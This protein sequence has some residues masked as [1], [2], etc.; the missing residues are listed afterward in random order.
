MKEFLGMIGHGINSFVAGVVEKSSTIIIVLLVI[1][2]GLS[3]LNIRIDLEAYVHNIN[4]TE[5]RYKSTIKALNNIHKSIRIAI[6]PTD[7][8]ITKIDDFAGES[9][10]E[11]TAD[12]QIQRKKNHKK[13]LY[14]NIKDWFGKSGN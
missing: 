2:I 12:E 3:I 6:D 13:Y 8:K 4:K 10:R 1:Q 5:S 11:L 9:E 7:E 14:H